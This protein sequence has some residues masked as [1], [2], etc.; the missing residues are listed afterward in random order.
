MFHRSLKLKFLSLS[1]KK[2]NS[3]LV[4]AFWTINWKC[5][6]CTPFY[7][8]C[9]CGEI[10]SIDRRSTNSAWIP[11]LIEPKLEFIN[12]MQQSI[13]LFLGSSVA[14]KCNFII[15]NVL[16]SKTYSFQITITTIASYL[17][18]I[19]NFNLLKL[20]MVLLTSKQLLVGFFLIWVHFWLV[21]HK[22]KTWTIQ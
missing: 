9:F 13:A 4:E 14:K 21:N 20:Q 3:V 11:E 17:L 1:T 5:T 22:L 2:S 10:L 19:H 7:T 8:Y 18:K 15:Q 16:S 12:G 6:S